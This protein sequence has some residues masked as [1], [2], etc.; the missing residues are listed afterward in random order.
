MNE[1]KKAKTFLKYV[2]G[3]HNSILLRTSTALVCCMQRL[4]YLLIKFDLFFNQICRDCCLA[5]AGHAEQEDQ[6]Q[7]PDMSCS[8]RQ[9]VLLISTIAIFIIIPCLKSHFQCFFMQWAGSQDE[10]CT[11][12]SDAT[13]R[14]HSFATIAEW[15]SVNF[16]KHSLKT[17]TNATVEA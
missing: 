15:L 4:I 13:S 12:D 11:Q 16:Q 14:L 9:Y 6:N 17:S 1:S 8:F 3:I 2:C 10:S 5:Q 7:S